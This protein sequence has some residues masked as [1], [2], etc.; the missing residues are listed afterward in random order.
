MNKPVLHGLAIIAALTLGPTALATEPDGNVIIRYGWPEKSDTNPNPPG[1][2]LTLTAVVPL[3]AARLTAT[4]PAGFDLNF[5]SPPSAAAVWPR[6]GLELGAIAAGQTV[7][8]DLDVVK[9]AKGSGVV[10]FVLEATAGD[11]VVREGVGVPVGVPGPEPVERD[12]VVE[13]PAGREVPA[14]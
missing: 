12:G 9:P 10:G 2:R 13:Y 5:H 14:P 4:H 8:V 6:E 7:V 3:T 1:L 11:H